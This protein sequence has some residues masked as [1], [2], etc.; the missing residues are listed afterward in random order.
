MYDVFGAVKGLLKVDSVSI[1]NNIFRLHYKAT[2]FI[3]VVFSLLLTQK[4]YFGD[5]IDCIVSDIDTSIMDTY[6]WIHSTFTIPSLIDK[7]VG[8]DVP[9]PGIS[10]PAKHGPEDQH[11]VK[12][13]KYYQWVTLFLYLQAI[14]FYVPRWLWKTFEGGKVK[15]LVMQ[16]NSPIV[17]DSCK[18]EQ[19]SLLVSYFS[20]NLH[21]HNW[22]FYKFFLCEVV[23]MVNVVGQIFFTN[24]F[25]DYEF[26]TY[27]S[28]VLSFTEQDFGT[29]VDPMD[30]VFP[31]VTKCTF[32]K[33]GPS[34]TV[35]RHDGL[36]VLPLNIF[37]EKI[38]HLHVV[39][40]YYCCCSF[41][42]WSFVP[43]RSRLAS[44]E[45]VEAVARKCHIGDWFVLYQLAKN[46]DP[47]IY[48]EFI[49]ELANKLQGKGTL[50]YKVTGVLL[51]TCSLLVTERQY[52]GDPID[53]ITDKV[54][55]EMMD[56][57]C[58]I[59]STYT[60]TN[61]SNAKVGVDIPH[62][63]VA[64]PLDHYNDTE[65]QYHKYYQWVTLVLFLQALMFYIPHYLWKTWERKTLKNLVM[66]LNLPV[67][68]E[69]SKEVRKQILTDYYIKNLHEFKSYTFRFFF[70]EVLNMVNVLLQLYLTNLFLDGAFTT[71]G[72]RVVEFSRQKFGTRLDPMDE[73]FPKVTK[74]TFYKYGPSGTV[75]RVDG[76]LIILAC[77][78]GVGL[79]YR[80]LTFHAPLRS[81]LLRTR[82]QLAK[83]DSVENLRTWIH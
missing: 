65:R 17:D 82:S 73:V 43:T 1:D 30:V 54:P 53:C 38:L 13:H 68:D 12:Y 60:V 10:N 78:S 63:G 15:M 79:F 39:L 41:W 32:Y 55:A 9:H 22:Y 14:L 42:Y 49:T 56:T 5:P 69:N 25:L 57:Y 74:C 51:I 19:K 36:C 80:L 3:L 81:R 37:N 8:V 27:G 67:F 29:R 33:Y 16:M 26:T 44:P 50:H 31:K 11:E 59:H 76:L 28:D 2:M 66:H 7:K 75:Q 21:N 46:M 48:K 72:T 52:L 4:Q 64:P 77:I 47:L 24:R 58:W 62:P 35:E 45:N 23:N 18:R 61:L 83:K 70:C 40:V 6:C 34:G 71:Y 20:L